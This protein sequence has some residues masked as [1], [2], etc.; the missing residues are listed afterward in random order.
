MECSCYLLIKGLRGKD[1]NTH[2]HN[3]SASLIQ[4]AL[5]LT[6]CAAAW[7][8]QC[9]QSFL[10]W[11]IWDTK[12]KCP[13]KNYCFSRLLIWPKYCVFRCKNI[14]IPFLFPPTCTVFEINIIVLCQ[15]SVF[16]LL[17][18][19]LGRREASQNDF[20]SLWQMCICW[21]HKQKTFNLHT[22]QLTLKP[23][24]L[25]TS[26]CTNC[27]RSQRQNTFMELNISLANH[28]F[29]S[30]L[31]V[32]KNQASENSPDALAENTD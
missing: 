8:K 9:K 22:G 6:G 11:V 27:W 25:I 18:A 20:K 14:E 19:L 13:V 1:T 29:V 32:T 10:A 26:Y 31:L 2:T 5:P 24:S 30:I 7:T 28:F 21:P 23:V 17:E 16:P 15:V 4:D 3:F 12:L